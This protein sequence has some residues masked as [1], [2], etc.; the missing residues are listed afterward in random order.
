MQNTCISSFREHGWEP[1]SVALDTG[2]VHGSSAQPGPVVTA[3]EPQ[4]AKPHRPCSWR[5]RH[6]AP[7]RQWCQAL[8]VVAGLL[9]PSVQ[10]RRKQADWGPRDTLPQVARHCCGHLTLGLSSGELDLPLGKGLIQGAK[11]HPQSS[12]WPALHRPGRPARRG[13]FIPQRPRVGIWGA[14][15]PPPSQ[16]L[17]AGPSAR[18]Q[19][20]EKDMDHAHVCSSCVHMACACVCMCVCVKGLHECV[21]VCA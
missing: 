19:D 6:H 17:P 7:G 16:R 18:R 13:L 21:W 2:P 4:Q 3:T 14:R 11:S 8:G 15:P 12:P 10:T 9:S 20:D 1:L 5:C